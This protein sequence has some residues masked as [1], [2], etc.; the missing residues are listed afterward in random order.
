MRPYNEMISWYSGRIP[1]QVLC[2]PGRIY[3]AYFADCM[4]GLKHQFSLPGGTYRLEWI[5]PVHGNTLLVKTLTHPGVYL[6]VDMPGY[7]GDL[8]LKMTKTA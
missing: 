3:L 5:N 1:A 7:V 8:F 6:P 2:D 4:P